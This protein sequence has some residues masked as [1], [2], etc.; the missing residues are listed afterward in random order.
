MRA[1]ILAAEEIQAMNFWHFNH[2]ADQYHIKMDQKFGYS[3]FF[4][5]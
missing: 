2:A 4:R 3:S 1:K 5:S